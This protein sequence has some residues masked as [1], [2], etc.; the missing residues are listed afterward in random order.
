MLKIEHTNKTHHFFLAFM[1]FQTLRGAGEL[2]AD[3][4]R[5]GQIV[6]QSAAARAVRATLGGTVQQLQQRLLPQPIGRSAAHHNP[7]AERA[8]VG[9]CSGSPA[10]AN[11]CRWARWEEWWES[12]RHCHWIW[13]PRVWESQ[14]YCFVDKGVSHAAVQTGYTKHLS[15]TEYIGIL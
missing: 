6:G 7:A 13:S 3:V 11:Q 1:S 14:C 8:L 9:Q 2:P 15:L 5:Q 12:D 10:A 4:W